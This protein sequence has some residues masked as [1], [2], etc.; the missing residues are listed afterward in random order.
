MQHRRAARTEAA[1][2]RNRG[3]AA[4]GDMI[5][6]VLGAQRS[7]MLRKFLEGGAKNMPFVK[8]GGMLLKLRWNWGWAAGSSALT[9][10][11]RQ[12]IP[13]ELSA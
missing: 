13:R 4:L 3:G 9:P 6:S 1:Q 5:F 10:I 2:R 12:H 7:I 8:K 11:F